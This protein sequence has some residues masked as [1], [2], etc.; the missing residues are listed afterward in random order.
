MR[1]SFFSSLQ[2]LYVC[3]GV[4]LLFRYGSRGAPVVAATACFPPLLF[5][6]GRHSFQR[7]IYLPTKSHVAPSPAGWQHLP[8]CARPHA[9]RGPPEKQTSVQ[10]VNRKNQNA[11][12]TLSHEQ[13]TY[14][15]VT[16][17]EF[18][19]S[20]A[21]HEPN[22]QAHG[23]PTQQTKSRDHAGAWRGGAPRAA[24]GYGQPRGTDPT[25]LTP[26]P[27]VTAAGPRKTAA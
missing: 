7:M 3:S 18:Q 17:E 5:H 26:S 2:V 6:T 23:T 11:H 12:I 15:P 24:W 1:C 27:R 20:Q 13:A 14:T 8:R 22:E 16:P 19:E 21:Q 4:F 25:P 10:G 9:S